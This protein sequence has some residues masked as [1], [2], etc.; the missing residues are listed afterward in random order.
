VSNVDEEPGVQYCE[1]N[2]AGQYREPELEDP[3]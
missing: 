2:T 1:Q 3:E